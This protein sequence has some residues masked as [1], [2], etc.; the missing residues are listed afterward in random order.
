MQNVGVFFICF[1]L[2]SDGKFS[3]EMNLNLFVGGSNSFAVATSTQKFG[4]IA[5]HVGG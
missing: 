2:V 3:N 1:R 4:V 5:I